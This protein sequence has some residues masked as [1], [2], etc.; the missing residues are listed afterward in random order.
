MFVYSL[1]ASTLKFFGVLALSVTTLL[2]LIAFIPTYDDPGSGSITSQVSTGAEDGQIINYSKIK[3][4][5]DRRALLAQFGWETGEEAVEVAEITL[6]SEFDA[7]MTEYNELQR[8]Q[9]L[10]LDKY[11]RKTVTR[12]TYEVTNYPDYPGKV[13]ASILVYRGKVIGGDVCTAEL[14]GFMH[15]FTPEVAMNG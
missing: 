1:R 15:G 5:E 10:D 8:R 12:Y 14:N 11:R 13:Y 3:T 9:G 7:V 2:V 4:G 6:P